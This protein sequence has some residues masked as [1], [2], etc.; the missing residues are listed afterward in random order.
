MQPTQS[1]V[2]HL[3]VQVLL[4]SALVGMFAFSLSLSED[5]FSPPGSSSKPLPGTAALVRGVFVILFALQSWFVVRSIR[6]FVQKRRATTR[7]Q[8]LTLNQFEGFRRGESRFAVRGTAW[9]SIRVDSRSA[10]QPLELEARV[11]EYPSGRQVGI[12]TIALSSE[13]THDECEIRDKSRLSR[14]LTVSIQTITP[15][16]Q[17]TPLDCQL[18]VTA[19]NVESSA[20]PSAG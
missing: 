18:T 9:I 13:V 19:S 4:L 11:V 3:S 1:V 8:G 6:E 17:R 10:K 16:T 5:Q 7:E 15:E 12:E 20:V 14:Q 2:K